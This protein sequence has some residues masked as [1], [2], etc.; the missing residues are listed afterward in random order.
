MAVDRALLL[1][2]AALVAYRL[3]VPIARS[4]RHGLRVSAVV[5]ES[6][7]SGQHLRHRPEPARA[8][9]ARRAVLRLAVHD[10]ALV[11]AGAPYSLSAAPDGRSLRITVKALG[12]QSRDL[13]SLR[14]GTRV[15]AEGP[16]GVFTADSRAGDRVVA[17]AGGVGV[18]PVR[19]LLADLPAGVT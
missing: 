5:R 2:A 1:V 6:P 7:E 14:V 9:G 17:I 8:G 15:L 3:V 19:A 11:V 10:P 18:V 13:G 12:D 16:Y 4:V